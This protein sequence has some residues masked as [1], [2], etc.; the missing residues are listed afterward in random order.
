MLDHKI[1]P[2]NSWFVKQIKNNFIAH[3]LL[4]SAAIVIC[5][6]GLWNAYFITDDYWML[7]WVRHRSTFAEAILAQ[8]G[9]GVRFLL[10][11]LLW[12]RV[13]LFDL[14]APPYYWSSIA[15]HVIMALI[16]YGLAIFW[17]RRRAVAFL[18][19]LLFG[20]TFAHY[21]V[22]TWITG[23][24]YSFAAIL[25]LVTLAQFAFYLRR[26]QWFW[27][28]GS[29]ITFLLLMLFLEMFLSLPLVLLAY[30]LI[31]GR[32][33]KPL[34]ALSWSDLRL[35]S[36]YW[37]FTGMYLMLQFS[38]VQAGSS[39][40]VVARVGYGPGIHMIGNLQ[41]LVHLIIPNV[42]Y[43]VL[44]DFFSPVVVKIIK[45]GTLVLALVGHALAV[46]GFWRGSSFV[47]FGIAFIYLTFLP[48]TLWE[49]GFAGAIRYMYLPAVGFS[50]LL[51]LFLA[52]LHHRLGSKESTGLSN[53][54]PRRIQW[55]VPV[56]VGLLLIFNLV[57]IQTWVQRHV[58]NSALRRVFVTE[59]IANYADVEPGTKIYIEVPAVKYVDL[60]EACTLIFEQD[61]ACKVFVS[62]D[63]SAIDGVTD[64]HSEPVYWLR[65]THEGLEQVFPIAR[66]TE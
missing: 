7:G 40:A 59:L 3:A 10:D 20:T 29:L 5:Y 64:D 25:Y 49:G 52:R 36:P 51:A 4:V 62:E 31:L 14:N 45:W 55:I 6:Y 63:V 32:E 15:Q 16:V 65:M 22:I 50:L 37:I 58:E 43:G 1:L 23:S 33:D 42:H 61:V 12:A 27:Y 28:A 26:R 17:T 30:H 13:R 19:A 8:S 57:V 60:R 11:A 9:Y 53:K 48:Y 39:E 35:H 54:A 44:I 46:Y 21:T 2:M 56:L 38:F 24:E 47:R 18:A 66:E 34:R 41:Y